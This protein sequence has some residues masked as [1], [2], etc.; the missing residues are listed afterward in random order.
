[1]C[2][3]LEEA[4]VTGSLRTWRFAPAQYK[5]SVDHYRNPPVHHKSVMKD[6][7]ATD[8]IESQTLIQT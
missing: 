6:A 4:A 8:T 7:N 1:M 2:S 3:P 5:D